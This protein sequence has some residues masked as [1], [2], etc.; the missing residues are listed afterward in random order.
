ML[1]C[2]NL[3]FQFILVMS[4]IFYTPAAYNNEVFPDWAEGIG[5][6]MVTVPLVLIVIGGIVAV[7]QKGSVS[8]CCIRLFPHLYNRNSSMAQV[9]R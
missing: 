9:C 5:W 2:L 3:P 6:L 7:I 4:A 1:L 8:F